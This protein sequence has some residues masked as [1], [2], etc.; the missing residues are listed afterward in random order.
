MPTSVFVVDDHELVRTGI[1]RLLEMEKDIRLLGEGPGSAEV[2]DAIVRL[3]PDVAVVDLEMPQIRGADFIRSI[4]NR[5][6]RIRV[7]ACTM[8]ASRGYVA[9]ALRSGADG[10]VLKSSPSDWLVACIR[11]VSGGKA[12]VDPALQD[13]IVR[14]V[15]DGETQILQTDLTAQETEVLRLVAEGCTNQEIAQQTHQSIESVK[16]RLRRC[17]HKLGAGDRAQAVAVAVRRNLI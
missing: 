14:L 2:L 8:H 15:Q 17:F 9:E 6:P 4:K 16:L 12:Y 10:Y 11:S 13:D 3:G 7:V 1:I 5:A